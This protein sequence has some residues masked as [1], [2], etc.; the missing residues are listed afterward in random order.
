MSNG[1]SGRYGVDVVGIG[2]RCLDV[3]L[4]TADM[5]N[6]EHGGWVSDFCFQGGGPVGTALV[7]ASRLGVRTGFIGTIGNDDIGTIKRRSLT[8]YGIDIS[9]T[10]TLPSPERQVAFVYVHEKT[11]ERVFARN[12]HM[13]D[14]PLTADQLDKDYVT[15]ARCLHLDGFYP[16]ASTAAARW[17]RDAKREVVLDME[18]PKAGELEP[19]VPGLVKLTDVLICGEGGTRAITGIA[20][21]PGAARSVLAMGPKVVVETLGERGSFTATARESFYTPAFRVN[22]VNTTGAGDVF[23]GAYIV[24]ILAGWDARFCAIFSSAVSAVTCATFGGPGRI[25]TMEDVL[26]FLRERGIEIPPR[27]AD[28]GARG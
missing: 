28:A 23:H 10:I 18:K 24:G 19:W 2:L 26:G 17:M 20:D 21:L 11:G 6:W 1:S 27:A 4:T 15:S 25:P 3:A 12:A 22:A 16:E 13:H 8:D 7:A 9:R 5:P 14:F